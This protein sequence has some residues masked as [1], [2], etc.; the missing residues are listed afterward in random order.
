MCLLDSY[1]QGRQQKV[2]VGR[3]HSRAL[4]KLSMGC[5]RAVLGPLLFLVL[6]NDLGMCENILMFTDDTQ[7]LAKIKDL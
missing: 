7:L 5:R 1:L 2:A 4:Y 3:V 6:I